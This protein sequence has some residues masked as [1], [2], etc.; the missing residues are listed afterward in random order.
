MLSYSVSTLQGVPVS[1]QSIIT[2][3]AEVL[4]TELT[5]ME[6]VGN[7]IGTHEWIFWAVVGLLCALSVTSIV[8]ITVAVKRGQ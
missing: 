6:K 4:V 7:Y 3:N 2:E 1:K 8:S 5:D